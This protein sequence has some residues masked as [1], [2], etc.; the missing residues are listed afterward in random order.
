MKCDWQISV[1]AG[2]VAIDA[3]GLGF[4]SLAGLIGHI[5]HLCHVSS[6]VCWP[7]A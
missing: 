7:G 5:R 4:D 1:L 6:K 3:A 2:D